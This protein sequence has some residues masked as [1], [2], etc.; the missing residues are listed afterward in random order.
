MVIEH[1]ESTDLK[2]FGI[3]V[4][5]DYPFFFSFFFSTYNLYTFDYLLYNNICWIAGGFHKEEQGC[6]KY[7]L[8]IFANE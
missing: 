5:M 4:L 3:V 2:C 8:A 1:I 6:G 7:F